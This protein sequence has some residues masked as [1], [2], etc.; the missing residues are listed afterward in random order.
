MNKILKYFIITF[1]GFVTAAHSL[2]M[3]TGFFLNR[4]YIPNVFDLFF[5]WIMLLV[6]GSMLIIIGV[7]RLYIKI[8]M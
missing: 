4:V 2:R 5:D 3:I 8:K 1:V 7:P 6:F